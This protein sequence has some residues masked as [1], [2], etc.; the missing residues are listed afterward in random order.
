MNNAAYGI[1]V[2]KILLNDFTA[3]WIIYS[4]E[5][6]HSQRMTFLSTES[7]H[8]DK[9]EGMRRTKQQK[10]ILWPAISSV[11]FR[12]YVKT[13]RLRKGLGP[14][15]AE[16][17]RGTVVRGRIWT[18]VLAQLRSNRPNKR[19]RDQISQLGKKST[20]FHDCSQGPSTRP[21]RNE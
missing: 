12:Q 13:S 17:P 5:R 10:L 7:K 3:F 4:R 21:C 1:I 6:K 19:W 8:L 16:F 20:Q 15:C 14:C 2:P 9:R 11:N 18:Q